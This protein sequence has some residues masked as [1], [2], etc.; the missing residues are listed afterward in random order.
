MEDDFAA[1]RVEDCC[2]T[3]DGGF[4][5]FAAK[6]D[7]LLFEARDLGIQIRYFK[8]QDGATDWDR[9]FR[10]GGADREGGVPDVVLKPLTAG[11]VREFQAQN[12]F[13]EVTCCWDVADGISHECNGMDHGNAGGLTDES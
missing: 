12:V 10:I 1:I 13:V 2:E 9:M 7:R 8:S 3:A 11:L 5:H 4:G 6:S